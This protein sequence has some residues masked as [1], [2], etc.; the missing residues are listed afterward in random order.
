MPQCAFIDDADPLS[1]LTLVYSQAFSGA[2]V[3]I[4]NDGS[5][6]ADD[7]AV[8]LSGAVSASSGAPAAVDLPDFLVIRNN[9][10]TTNTPNGIRAR[11]EAKILKAADLG[12]V[13]TGMDGA[14]D[15]KVL[16]VVRGDATI[17]SIAVEAANSQLTVNDPSAASITLEADIRVRLIVGH[18][19]ATSTGVTAT[20]TLP[21][22]GTLV[23]GATTRH[24]AYYQIATGAP[25]SARTIDMGDLGANI[26]QI[27]SI[28]FN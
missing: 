13:L 5:V 17:E 1:A 7:V 15:D 12:A 6:V 4:P 28:I 21:T 10:I 22:N 8:V 16:L 24:R 25:P 3:T 18:A 19:M 11:L 23:A 14:T 9:G 26:L 27:A 2:T 20:G